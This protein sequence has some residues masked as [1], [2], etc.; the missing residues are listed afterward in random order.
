MTMER[1]MMTRIDIKMLGSKEL[2]TLRSMIREE[3]D[4]RAE[5]GQELEDVSRYKV[6]ELH[7]WSV[8][9]KKEK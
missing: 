8:R 6:I 2:R 4:F 1:K 3:L 9:V 7:R 5:I